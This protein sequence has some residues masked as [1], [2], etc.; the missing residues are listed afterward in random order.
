[1]NRNM[2]IFLIFLISAT[3]LAVVFLL[4]S[5]IFSI[6]EV[7]YNSVEKDPKTG[8]EVTIT[9]IPINGTGF[10]APLRDAPFK[11]EIS[12]GSKLI[13]VLK[14]E[15]Q[16]GSLVLKFTGTGDVKILVTPEHALKPTLF[17]FRVQH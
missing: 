15:S 5:F 12:E 6:Y 13:I 16:S 7:T 11:Y 3:I 2:S 10:R 8:D 1:M 4:H 9:A 14:D 17:E